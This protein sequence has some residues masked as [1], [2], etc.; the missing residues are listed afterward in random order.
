M[1]RGELNVI[2]DSLLSIVKEKMFITSV[3]FGY[4]QRIDPLLLR[5]I[6]ERANFKTNNDPK[7]VLLDDLIFSEADLS[8]TKS[9][10][11]DLL[12]DAE[13]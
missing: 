2:R 10:F 1:S 9:K 3:D 12:N 8:A 13:R 7:I 11:F 5:K 6:V 4:N